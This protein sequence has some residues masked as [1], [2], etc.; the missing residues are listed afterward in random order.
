MTTTKHRLAICPALVL[1]VFAVILGSVAV[2]GASAAEDK[3]KPKPSFAGDVGPI[4]RNRC[5]T[6]HNADKAKGGLNLET[7]STAMQ[8]GGSGK[9][10]EPGDADGSRLWELV[11]HSDQPF[12]PPKS[13][14]LP[15]AELDL[16][17][18]WIEAGA[19]ETS[20]SVVA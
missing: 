13:P 7:F 20:G 17:K 10:I 16:I 14:K 4:L 6:C 3:A 5:N 2:R 12:M 15:D 18:R 1:A 19:P 11:S 9:V 8:G